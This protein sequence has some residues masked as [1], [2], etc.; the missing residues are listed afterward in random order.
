VPMSVTQ[1]RGDLSVEMKE[2]ILTCLEID[3]DKRRNFSEIERMWFCTKLFDG[4]W[5]YNYGYCV[6]RSRNM[7]R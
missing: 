5:H 4:V 7:N 1:L 6:D 2:L 3:M